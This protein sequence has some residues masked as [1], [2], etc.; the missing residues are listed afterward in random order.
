MGILSNE[1]SKRFSINGASLFARDQKNIFMKFR[2]LEAGFRDIR[3]QSPG[4]V[5][6]GWMR[7]R[8]DLDDEQPKVTGM[9]G[10]G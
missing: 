4:I 3:M 9:R 2:S 6:S 10:A 7:R 8:E 5:A 1:F